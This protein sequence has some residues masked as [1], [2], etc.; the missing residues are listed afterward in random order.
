M[1]FNQKGFLPYLIT[2][3]VSYTFLTVS[4]S[5]MCILEREIFGENNLSMN[6]TESITI[7]LFISTLTIEIL[8]YIQDK[9]LNTG[10]IINMS[11]QIAIVSTTVYTLGYLFNWFP[12][13]FEL[14]YIVFVFCEIL[15]VYFITYGIMMLQNKRITNKIN[16]I[17]QEKRN[18]SI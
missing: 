7:Q 16:K 8:M 13:P 14:K 2:A 4:M 17:I 11:I 5:I 10:M 6:L 15:L 9:F 1:Y 3:C 12:T 18:K